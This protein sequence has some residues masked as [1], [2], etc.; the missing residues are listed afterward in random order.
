MGKKTYLILAIGAAIGAIAMAMI[1]SGAFVPRAIAQ[2]PTSLRNVSDVN[3]AGLDTLKS[4]DDAFAAISNY[5]L[6]STVHIRSEN[7]TGRGANGRLSGVMGGE[8]SGMIYRSDGYIITNEHVVNGFNKVTVTLADGRE[9]PGKVIAA[10]ESDIALV[11]IEAKNLPTLEFADSSRVRPGQYAIAVG[12]PFGLENTVTIGHIS[13]LGRPSEVPDARSSYGLRF[14]PDMIQTDAA[15]NMGNSGGPLVDVEG[16]VIGIN[17]AIFSR[18]GESVGIGFAIPGKQAK[19]IADLL[20]EKGKVT[21]GY[22]GILPLNL[23]EFQKKEMNLDGGALVGE[24]RSDIESP[25]RDAGIKEGDVVVKIGSIVVKDQMD[26]RNAMLRYGPGDTVDIEVIRD[27]KHQTFRVKVVSP[28][29]PK[30]QPQTR[31]P[32]G[33]GSPF[34]FK[35]PDG[36]DVPDVLKEFHKQFEE[37]GDK[38]VEPLRSGPAKLGVNVDSTNANSRKQFRIPQNVSGAVVM[39][40]EAGSVAERIGLKAGDVITLIGDKTIKSAEDLVAAMKDVKWGDTK[41]FGFVR[42]SENSRLEQTRD[43]KF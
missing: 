9:F 19:M 22:L 3:A 33:G 39:N 43:T 32:L 12:S 4:L 18:T 29:K 2:R 42:F 35:M 6:S 28:P 31:P 24:F 8:G 14:Y 41:R 37:G 27:G 26:L 40:V 7:T 5:A 17:T 30:E 23:K 21:R 34:R 16:R 10:Q 1:Q 38:D 20:I 36:S 11:K 15:I 25:A 13:A